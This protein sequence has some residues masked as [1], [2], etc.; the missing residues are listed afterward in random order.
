MLMTVWDE[1]GDGRSLFQVV[2]ASNA[3]YD[4]ILA[5]PTQ[6]LQAA[7]Q[8]RCLLAYTIGS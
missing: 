4:R 2:Q 1:E 3:A 7:M 5:R 8:K 6:A